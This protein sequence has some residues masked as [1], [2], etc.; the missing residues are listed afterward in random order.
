MIVRYDIRGNIGGADVFQWG[1]HAQTDADLTAGATV[2]AAALPALVNGLWPASI[3]WKSVRANE[4][5]EASGAIIQTSEVVVPACTPSAALPLPPEVALCVTIRPVNGLIAGRLYLPSPSV[6]ALDSNGNVLPT[7]QPVFADRM[8][9]FFQ[10]ALG[11]SSS[12]IRVG[13]YSRKNHNWVGAGRIEV[14]S[15]F[16]SQRRR[17]NKLVEIRL[18]RNVL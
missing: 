7:A 12:P 18:S 6:N 4:V 11:A 5:N 2:V 8:Q 3:V 9:T 17:R 10:T 1:F 14:G 15:V 13:I 16:D